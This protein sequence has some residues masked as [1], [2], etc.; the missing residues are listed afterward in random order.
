VFQ[1]FITARVNY[2]SPD[3]RGVI[4]HARSADL[5]KWEVLPPVTIPGEFGQ[6]EVPQLVNIRN[7]Y[8]LLFS[9]NA[10]DH[11]AERLRR[12][13]CEAVTGTHYFVS[14]NPLGSFSFE[15][16][17]FL[18]GNR[19]GTLYSGKIIQTL[20]GKWQMMAFNNYSE[21]GNFVGTISDPVDF[22]F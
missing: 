14:D 3:G 19:A 13:K 6:L 16:D 17:H 15:T 10:V 12:T 4:A 18:Q 8:Y 21:D 2:G 1:A 20:N 22:N 7:K 5:Y 9:T 11:S